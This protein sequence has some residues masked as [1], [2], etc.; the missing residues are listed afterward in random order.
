[1]LFHSGSFNLTLFHCN[2]DE[3]KQC[4]QS[5]PLSVWSLHVL[6][7]STRVSLSTL[8]SSHV[9]ESC[10]LGLLLCL[11]GFSVSQYDR[12]CEYAL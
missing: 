12:E 9:P 3:K 1:M 10:M 8:V 4:F 5:G 2:I 7:L 11:H 6:P